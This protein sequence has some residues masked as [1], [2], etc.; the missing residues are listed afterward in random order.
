MDNNTI[1]KESCFIKTQSLI[2]IKIE[3]NQ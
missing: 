3:Q 1:A 2:C